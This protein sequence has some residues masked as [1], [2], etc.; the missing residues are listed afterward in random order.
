MG[1]DG[2]QMVKDLVKLYL[3]DVPT[4]IDEMRQGIANQNTD[5]LRRAA[6][7]LKG[8]SSQVGALKLAAL[9][10]E[11]ETVAKAGSVE[12]TESMLEKVLLEFDQVKIDFGAEFTP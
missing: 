7:T 8:N 2:P 12:G 5:Q 4:L 3:K 1:E 6:H 11:L 10:A 9:S